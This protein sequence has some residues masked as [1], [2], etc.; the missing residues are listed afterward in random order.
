MARPGSGVSPLLM[1]RKFLEVIMMG[2]VDFVKD[3][4]PFYSR[5]FQTFEEVCCEVYLLRL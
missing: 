1:Y 4:C 2:R 5:V 3:M